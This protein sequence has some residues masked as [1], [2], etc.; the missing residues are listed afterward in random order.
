MKIRPFIPLIALAITCNAPAFAAPAANVPIINWQ[1]ESGLNS[2]VSLES[3]HLKLSDLVT[4]VN[5]QT[6]VRLNLPPQ[7]LSRSLVIRANAMPLAALLPALGQLYGLEWTRDP[8]PNSFSARVAATPTELAFLQLG[9]LNELRNRVR[10]EATQTEQQTLA[11]THKW[12]EAQLNQGVALSELPAPLQSALQQAKLQR[13]ALN[14]LGDWAQ[15]TPFALRSM[16]VRVY[17]P[18]AGGASTPA[19]PRFMLVDENGAPVR[20][21]GAME[22]P[23]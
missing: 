9:D 7:L 11:A 21:L 14:Y 18:K 2:P 22:L 10:I 4:A 12:D 17:L 19:P 1:T 13:V 3:A 5:T 8:T 16:R 20:D 23:E 6:K 15:W